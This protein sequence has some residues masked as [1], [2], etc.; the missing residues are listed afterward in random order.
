MVTSQGSSRVEQRLIELGHGELEQQA[1]VAGN[2]VRAVTTGNLVF[3]SGQ[4]P[5]R[6]GERLYLGRLGAEIDVE[7]GKKAA[8]LATIGQLA[9]LKAEIGNL[10]RVTRI[11]KILGFVNSAPDFTDQSKV[12]NGASDLLVQVFG[13]RGRHA[14]AAVGVAALPFGA[15]V[16]I[17]MV[18]Q[19]D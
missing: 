13:D 11:V 12:V 8:E 3:L 10:D 16:E 18:V 14:R 2:Y 7:T 9:A 5:T 1:P 6:T 15:A 4:L 17:E 19:V